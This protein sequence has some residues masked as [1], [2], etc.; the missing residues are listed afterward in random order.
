ME[1]HLHR[2]CSER[3]LCLSNYIYS[4]VLD[5]R[6]RRGG[7]REERRRREENSGDAMLRN[8]NIILKKER[9]KQLL[10]YTHTQTHTSQLRATLKRHEIPAAHTKKEKEKP[11][12]SSSHTRTLENET[13]SVAYVA[14]TD[15]AGRIALGD[16][17]VLSCLSPQ[18]ISSAKYALP[19]NKS[20]RTLRATQICL[21]TK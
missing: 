9:N 10:F 16:I 21:Q 3:L 12:H 2:Q 20:A 1:Q 14:T 17:C 4:K 5:N 8:K 13:Q 11:V 6:K 7:K 15:E 19:D 18:H